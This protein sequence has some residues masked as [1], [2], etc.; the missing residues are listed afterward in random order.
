LR[1]ISASLKAA[2]HQTRLI[3]VSG[4]KDSLSGRGLESIKALAKP[5]NLIGISSM[6]RSSK[7]AKTVINALKSLGKPIVWGG[8]HPTLFPEDCAGHAD[9]ICRGEGEGFMVEM[10]DRVGAGIGY[11]DISNGGYREGERLVLNDVRPVIEDLDQLPFL[12]FSFADH[13]EIDR[14]GESQPL[15]D[16]RLIS[17]ILFSGSRGCYYNCYYCSNARLKV[18]Y[19]DKGRY[20]RKMSVTAFVEAA[21]KC[22]ELFPRAKYF[23]FTDEDFMARSIEEIRELALLYPD[24]V[25]LPFEC[26]ASPQ[27]I[28][29]EKMALMVKAGLWRID[30]GAESGSDRVK[31][32]VFN[33]PAT[34]KIVLN[35]AAIIN[36]FPQVVAYYFFIIGNPYEGREDL[37]ETI[38]LIKQLPPPFFIRTYNLVFIPGTDLY[39]KACRD[40][41]ISGLEDSGYELDFLEG[42]DPR[43]HSWKTLNL[44]LNGLISLMTGKCTRRRLGFVPRV[45]LRAM[46]LPQIVDFHDRHND[47]SKVISLMAI[48]GLKM[49][50]MGFVMVKKILKDP[51]SIYNLKNIVK[52]QK[53]Y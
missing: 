12:D 9:L 7:K 10:A 2:G 24:K 16:M 47:A 49:R 21:R 19:R 11:R 48:G 6:S 32:K 25:G 27:Q 35:A 43:S 51:R 3:F 34:N 36:K 23:Y 14:Q 42:F 44:Y 33:R 37:M 28:T 20:V 29:E 18:L 41:I 22:R 39:E 31:K 26:M 15:A 38:G 5:S 45:F 8:I 4:G 30:V 13:F 46:T 40:G 1:S 52:K 53:A 50:R 17:C